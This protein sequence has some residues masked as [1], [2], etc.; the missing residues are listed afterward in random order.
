M[1]AQNAVATAKI[2]AQTFHPI[3]FRGRHGTG[4][5]EVVYQI[6]KELGLPVEERRASQM[7]EGDLL[8]LPDR[9]ENNDTTTFLPPEWYMR[10]CTEPVLLFFDE[11]DRAAPQ[12]AQGIFEITDSRKIFG[13]YLHTGTVVMAAVNSGSGN[14]YQVRTMD[15]AELDRWGVI[16]FTPSVEDWIQWAENNNVHRQVIG[17]I[18]TN[19]G[20]L[21]NITGEF[22]PNRV[23]PSRRS[24][25]RFS[26]MIDEIE[27]AEVDDDQKMALIFNVGEATFGQEISLN[28]R[29]YMQNKQIELAK[30]LSDDRE[31]KRAIESEMDVK[32]DIIE[33]VKKSKLNPEDDILQVNINKEEAERIVKFA[34]SL[35]DE[36]KL[37]LINS[38][39]PGTRTF[40]KSSTG[41]PIDEVFGELRYKIK[42]KEE[43]EDE[44]E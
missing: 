41:Y 24:W 20:M 13:K 19:P 10:A 4:K 16:D 6:G 36:Q 17:Y 18:R 15:P 3:M 26:R 25:T 38:I 42:L 40:I 35:Y 37:I 7:T 39:R 1:D 34:K 21:E 2:F 9:G 8:G 5:S 23:T 43:G 11:I 22:E 28:F 33:Q 31:L 30:I 32:L 14:D 27:G 44:K 12:V 29:N